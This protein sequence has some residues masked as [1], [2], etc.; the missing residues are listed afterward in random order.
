MDHF[1]F[2]HEI[3]LC[4]GFGIMGDL[5]STLKDLDSNLSGLVQCSNSSNQDLFK[6]Q[7]LTRIAR[8]LHLY[9]QICIQ[10]AESREGVANPHREALECSKQIALLTLRHIL[11]ILNSTINEGFETS[12]RPPLDLHEQ[13]SA[14]F[15]RGPVKLD[16]FQY[17]YG[18]LDCASQLGCIVGIEEY[19]N[20]F[21]A[22]MRS[23]IARSGEASFRLKAVS[24]S[25]FLY[26][27]KE[28]FSSNF[29]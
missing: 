3:D 8:A 5:G 2:G 26:R 29:R 21:A 20:G 15:N 22:R 10:S 27:D 9:S 12:V 14:L 24:N 6:L 4:Q 1:D 13:I 11:K 18:L 17:L 7:G 25:S 23:I 16:R 28:L 19:P